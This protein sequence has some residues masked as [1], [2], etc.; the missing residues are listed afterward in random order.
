MKLTFSIS[1]ALVALAVVNA[2]PVSVKR[3]ENAPQLTI[4]LKRNVGAPRTTFD[5]NIDEL[6]EGEALDSIALQD[7]FDQFSVTV[8]IGTPPKEFEL[9]VDT[10]SQDTWVIAPECASDACKNRTVYNPDDSTSVEKEY[11]PF[12]LT[13]GD[14]GIASGDVYTDT[15]TVSAATVDRQSFGSATSLKTPTF[16][17]KGDGILGLPASDRRNPSF[18]DNAFEAG[19]VSEYIFSLYMPRKGEG[20]LLLGGYNTT[21]FT[22]NL[23]YLPIAFTMLWQVTIDDMAYRNRSLGISL[24]TTVETATSLIRLDRK[25]INT[26]YAAIPGAKRL[27]PTRWTIPCDKVADFTLS[28]GGVAFKIP[29]SSITQGPLT[30]GS[31]FCLSAIAGGAKTGYASLGL[32]FLENYYTVFDKANTPP[33]IGFATIA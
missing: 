29:G 15:V 21:R 2:S 17:L 7:Q 30:E 6:L 33:R 32:A 16:D 8:A 10:A 24:K 14:G 3:A 27:S 12:S 1:L 31:K 18:F 22:G 25:S 9:I 19:S 26:L 23:T 11:R 28:M 4:P 20:E 5:K 13:F